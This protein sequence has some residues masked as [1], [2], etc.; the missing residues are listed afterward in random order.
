MII[1][2]Y[3]V[4][5]ISA[6]VIT[7]AFAPII[8]GP[9]IVP[10]GTLLIGTT[11]ILRDL[12][13]RKYGRSNAYNVIVTALVLSAVTSFLLGDSLMIVLASALS[14]AISETADTEIFTRL[15]AS[16]AK[17]VLFSGVIGGTIDSTIFVI[18]GLS[19]LGAGFLPWTAIPSA[20]I[21]QMVV[22]FAMQTVGVA[23]IFKYM[24]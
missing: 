1:L 8:A 20:I 21:G 24:K 23:V 3:L 11:F 16:F 7:A 18:V 5:I 13:Q 12:V 17:R 10:W 15:R 4:A 14:F 6:N 2:L 9:F 19:P 22:K